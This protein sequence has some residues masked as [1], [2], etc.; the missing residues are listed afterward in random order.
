[1]LTARD[2]HLSILLDNGKVLIAGGSCQPERFFGVLW[3]G[4]CSPKLY[5]PEKDAVLFCP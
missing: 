2:A 1:M 3:G 4:A 5:E